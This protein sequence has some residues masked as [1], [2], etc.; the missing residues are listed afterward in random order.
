MFQF[1]ELEISRYSEETLF[2]KW[3]GDRHDDICIAS[4]ILESQLAKGAHLNRHKHETQNRGGT[5]AHEFLPQVTHKE[6]QRWTS[7]IARSMPSSEHEK[8]KDLQT[9][10]ILS[11]SSGP[12][13][14]GRFKIFAVC[15]RRS[16]ENVS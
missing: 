9:L 10:K 5:S 6:K 2:S 16:V 3:H 1:A 15:P 4:T 13:F 14:P 11:P 7:Q 12:L 8:R